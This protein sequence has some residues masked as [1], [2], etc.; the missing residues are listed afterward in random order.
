[1]KQ[2]KFLDRD[3]DVVAWLD[4]LPRRNITSIAL[5]IEGE[6][7]LHRYGEHLC[8]IQIFDGRESV[9]I[10]PLTVKMRPVQEMLENPDITKVMFDCTSDR[11]LL[12]RQYG[13]MMQGILDLVPAVELLEYEKKGL[14]QVLHIC[15]GKELKPKKKFQR[16]DWMK[17]PIDREALAYAVGD[18]NHLFTLQQALLEELESGN[19]LDEYYARNE[20]VRNRPIQAEATP[21]VLKKN[22]FRK[23]PGWSKELFLALFE[24]RDGYAR[25]LDLPPNS[26]VSNE[27][28]FRLSSLQLETKNIAFR[29]RIPGKVRDNIRR[30]FEGIMRR[31]GSHAD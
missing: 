6:F 3:E 14:D 17:R 29:G 4:G 8:L 26:V 24:N 1:M 22:R 16:Y 30:D 18:V 13:I 12:F 15:L 20:E 28:L 27:E 19:L 2:Y 21:G 25:K 10:D 5:D 11:T 9:V 23:L 7:N 31:R